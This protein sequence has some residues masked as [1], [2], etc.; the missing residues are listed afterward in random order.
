MLHIFLKHAE[1]WN[2]AHFLQAIGAK[3]NVPT[4]SKTILCYK[5]SAPLSPT[6]RVGLQ[7]PPPDPGRFWNQLAWNA[8]RLPQACRGLH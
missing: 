7:A 4:F 2:T 3:K 8:A 6:V 1:T 5:G